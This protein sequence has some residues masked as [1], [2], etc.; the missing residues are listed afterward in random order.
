MTAQD[1]TITAAAEQ[2]QGSGSRHS[3]LARLLAPESAPTSLAGVVDAYFDLAL[4]F[5][6][7]QRE[8]VKDLA[9]TLGRPQEGTQAAADVE[10]AERERA[11][12]AEREQAARERAEQAAREQA[13]REQAER[14]R[15]E[16]AARER[17]EQAA[18]ERAERERAEQAKREQAEQAEQEQAK[19]DEEAKRMERVERY[20]GLSRV[21]LV[22]E[23]RQ[24]GLP[25]AGNKPQL[26]ERLLDADDS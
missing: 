12:Q 18:R 6:E 20:R 13:E 15:A 3:R 25:R 10:Q 22:E 7:A 16:Q 4:G 11:E 19:Q 23:L 17:A 8:M 14:E 26:V 21:Q 1:G 9:S 5:L 2:T 24:R